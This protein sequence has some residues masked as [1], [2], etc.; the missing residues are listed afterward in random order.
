MFRELGY[1]PWEARAL[2]KLGRLLDDKGDPAGACW[3]W[4]SALGIF[5]E[6]DMPEA[7]EVATRLDPLGLDTSG[8]EAAT[9]P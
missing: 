9:P 5:R 8:N 4:H 3:A 7:A 6:L 1:R 2:N